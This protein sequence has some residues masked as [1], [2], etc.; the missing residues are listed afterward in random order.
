[1][2]ADTEA[3]EEVAARWIAARDK[4]DWTAG[5]QKALDAWLAA[6]IAHRVSFLRLEAVWNALDGLR[7]AEHI[8]LRKP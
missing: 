2:S 1:M 7:N 3:V 5:Q 6:D 4:G 8:A